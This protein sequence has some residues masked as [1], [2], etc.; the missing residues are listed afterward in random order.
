[1]MRR[2]PCRRA[3]EKTRLSQSGDPPG[4]LDQVFDDVSFTFD[5]EVQVTMEAGN[6][7]STSGSVR[8]TDPG[9]AFGLDALVQGMTAWHHMEDHSPVWTITR[10]RTGTVH[11][12]GSPS[13]VSF[14]VDQTMDFA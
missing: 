6:W 2:R 7:G 14:T 5:L 10:E 9:A 13:Q 8:V 1:M 12:G 11:V 4:A 3:S